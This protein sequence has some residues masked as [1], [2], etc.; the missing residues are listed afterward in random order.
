MWRSNNIQISINLKE[1]LDVETCDS[2]FYY[3]ESRLVNQDEPSKNSIKDTNSVE[4]YQYGQFNSNKSKSLLETKPE[5]SQEI[6]I[7]RLKQNIEN[8]VSC[9]ICDGSLSTFKHVGFWA[10]CHRFWCEKCLHYTTTVDKV[11][12]KE[13][14]QNKR[15]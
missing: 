4:V 5:L 2:Y 9:E 8:D 13:T 15:L 3:W 14:K 7:I 12:E 1:M 6:I 10:K 11:N